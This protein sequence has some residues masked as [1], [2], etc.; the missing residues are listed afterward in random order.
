MRRED[1]MEQDLRI[2]EYRLGEESFTFEAMGYAAAELYRPFALASFK[3]EFP[4]RFSEAKVTGPI[5][6]TASHH[7][8][9]SHP[10]EIDV[11]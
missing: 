2:Y 8:H 9:L 5:D 7:G 6:I 3:E 4:D 1:E 11:A 10:N